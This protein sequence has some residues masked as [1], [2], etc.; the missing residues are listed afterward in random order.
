VGR[1]IKQWGVAPAGFLTAVAIAIAGHLA[2][3]GAQQAASR[4]TIKGHVQLKG[5]PPGN[6]IIRM[7]MDPMCARMTAGK[8][9]I[10]EN[11]VAAADGSLANVF[12]RLQGSFPQVP[13]PSAAVMIDQRGCIYSPRVVGVRVGQ[14]L[15][16]RNDD[17]LLHN[18]HGL[19]A[20]A[21]SFNV[22]E[23]KAGMV[24]QFKLKDEEVMLHLKCDI[25]SWM[26]AYVGVVT[27]PYFAVSGA[28]G[29][30]EI[31]D[32]PPGAYTIQ[33]WHERYGPIAMNVRVRAGATAMVEFAYTG[34]EKAPTA[35]IEDLRVHGRLAAVLAR[36]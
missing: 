36:N 10:Q 5:K 11:V 25:H 8:R 2:P 7:G 28:T 20:R 21:N 29:A 19:S 26:T 35:G 33:A 16:V 32:V 6:P 30:F 3:I 1:S 34:D 13:V 18:V 27:N 23:P 4:G 9:V 24:Q 31:D 17:E 15:Q 12:V 22:S 14:V